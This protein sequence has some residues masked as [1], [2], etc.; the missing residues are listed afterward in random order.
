MKSY[1]TIINFF[2]ALMVFCAFSMTAQAQV[3]TP[4]VSPPAQLK[5]T[6]ATTDIIVDYSRPQVITNGN[7]RTGKI[8]G[9]RV[10]YGFQKINFASQNEIPWRAGANENTTI[11][12]SEDVKVGGKPVKAGK[13]GF[14][15][16]VKENNEATIILSNINTSWGSFW[17]D[18]KEDVARVE[19]K[20]E[21]IGFTNVLTFD[22][23]DLGSNYGTLALSWE[24]KRFPVKIEVDNKEAVAANLRAQLLGQGG[25]GWQGPFGAAQYCAQN[26]FN[27]EEALGWIDQAIQ[28]QKNYNTLSVK[29][30]LLYQMGEQDKAFEVA[31]ESATVANI[32]QL[33]ALGYQML[34][35]KLTD[36]A[37]KY[38][39]MNVEKNPENANVYDSLGEAYFTK[40]DKDNA[41]KNFKKSLSLNPPANVKQN[42]LSFLKRM[43][44]EYNK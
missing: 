5:Q 37:I 22:F 10:A 9:Q 4:R 12:F 17:Y 25:F 2:L 24:K 29:S 18:Q 3:N 19:V 35:L 34:Q 36:K 13:Y 23:V 39:K 32:N 33:N 38:F 41:I 14:F 20:T 1:P 16:A 30:T 31:D 28:Q 11:T 8:W 43:G 42:S 21:D 15:I 27:H 7:D 26:N 44:V 6:I 40:G